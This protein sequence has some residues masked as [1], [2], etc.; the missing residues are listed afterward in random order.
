MGSLWDFY[1]ERER[2]ACS[3]SVSSFMLGEMKR[4]SLKVMGTRVEKAPRLG[5]GHILMLNNIWV[6]FSLLSFASFTVFKE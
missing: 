4:V 2:V 5:A 3:D 1:W 6:T